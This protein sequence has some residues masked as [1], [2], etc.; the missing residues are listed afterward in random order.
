MYMGSPS[1]A[2]LKG[3]PHAGLSP[4]KPVLEDGTALWDQLLPLLKTI[5]D[6][7]QIKEDMTF[8]E[9]VQ[10]QSPEMKKNYH[11]DSLNS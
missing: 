6:Q 11:F 1:D 4:G 2:T 3:Q 8:L 5:Q 10:P 7:S 9:N